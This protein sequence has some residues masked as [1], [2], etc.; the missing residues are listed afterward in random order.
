MHLWPS[1]LL[2]MYRTCKADGL[3]YVARRRELGLQCDAF[4]SEV[5]KLQIDH[6][7]QPR[8]VFRR[9]NTVG[10]CARVLLLRIAL[11]MHV[12]GATHA[13]RSEMQQK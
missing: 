8:A 12:A 11:M 4:G 10:R 9:A 5:Q 13:R 7:V 1:T 2:V 6:V 3:L